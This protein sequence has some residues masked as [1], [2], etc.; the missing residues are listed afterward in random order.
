MDIREVYFQ[1]IASPTNLPPKIRALRSLVF[2]C[3]LLVLT[4]NI[5]TNTIGFMSMTLGIVGDPDI[6]KAMAIFL[7]VSLEFFGFVMYTGFNI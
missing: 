1:I 4:Y 2:G 5:P 6:A 3:I 7:S